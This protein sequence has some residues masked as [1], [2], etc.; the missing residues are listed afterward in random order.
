MVYPMKNPH[1]KSLKEFK[2]G[3]ILLGI[4][5]LYDFTLLGLGNLSTN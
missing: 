4:L 1:E 3:V 2:T 5:G